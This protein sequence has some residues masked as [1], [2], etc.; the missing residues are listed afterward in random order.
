MKSFL[1]AIGVCTFGIIPGTTAS[2]LE[3]GF[4]GPCYGA[5]DSYDS[6]G[7]LIDSAMR[8][9]D[10]DYPVNSAG[11]AV[12]TKDN[13]FTISP[14]GSLTYEG[15]AVDANGNPATNHIW[16]L[17]ITVP[18]YGD[19]DIA[20]GGDENLE[21]K[22]GAEGTIDFDEISMINNFGTIKVKANFFL[23]SDDFGCEV[24]GA[25]VI[26]SGST[27]IPNVGAAAVAVIGLVG[28]WRARRI[29]S[30]MSAGVLLGLGAGIAGIANAITALNANALLIPIGIGAFCGLGVNVINK[31]INKKD[32]PKNITG[33][34]N[35]TEIK[36]TNNN[37]NISNV[38]DMSQMFNDPVP[39]DQPVD[40]NRDGLFTEAEPLD[41][42]V[43]ANRNISEVETFDTGNNTPPEGTGLPDDEN[44]R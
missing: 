11:E 13:P 36:N 33:L 35:K 24:S 15:I 20:D 16:A 37:L 6:D 12:F 2:A 7:A 31:L 44:S 21:R 17:Q 43:D 34:E 32:T 10:R 18:F 26:T 5:V 29:Q 8:E 25:W 39:S 27:V 9:V 3:N 1:V 28:L 40:A 4:S 41:Q 14:T 23:A 22:E 19:V 30:L 42:P 38:N